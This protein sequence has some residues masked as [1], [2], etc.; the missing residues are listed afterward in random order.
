MLREPKHRPKGGLQEIKMKEIR[1]SMEKFDLDGFIKKVLEFLESVVSEECDP[2]YGITWS[3]TP[4]GYPRYGSEEGWDFKTKLLDEPVILFFP[5]ASFWGEKTVRCADG[6]LYQCPWKNT[7]Y[8]D[9]CE[10]EDEGDDEENPFGCE[11][12]VGYLVRVQDGTI[13]ITSGRS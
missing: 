10:D 5:F 7:G 4:D 13:C 12:L 2:T 11:D 8:W 6:N 1:I 9:P 3:E